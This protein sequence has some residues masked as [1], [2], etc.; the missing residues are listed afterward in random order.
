M[1]ALLAATFIPVKNRDSSTNVGN[2]TDGLTGAGSSSDPAITMR[3]GSVIPAGAC[4]RRAL[5]TASTLP[6]TNEIPLSWVEHGRRFGPIHN[7][8]R[9]PCRSRATIAG[10]DIDEVVT[11]RKSQLRKATVFLLPAAGA[12]LLARVRNSRLLGDDVGA[13]LCG[14]SSTGATVVIDH[15]ADVEVRRKV[16]VLAI[17]KSLQ[18]RHK[19]NPVRRW[20]PRRRSGHCDEPSHLQW[21]KLE[22]QA[23]LHHGLDKS[24]HARHDGAGTRG[25]PLKLSRYPVGLVKDVV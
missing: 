6:A 7:R 18:V 22:V 11:S 8:K 20:V 12:K 5:D 4:Q 23:R 24:S 21:C 13:G 10:A 16:E 14:V 15:V 3:T 17:D 25:V 2:F 1:L 9:T 19:T